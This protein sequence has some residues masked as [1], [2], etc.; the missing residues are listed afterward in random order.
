MPSY[1]R[2]D[3]PD[4]DGILI[5]SV[6]ARLAPERHFGVPADCEGL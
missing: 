4:M 2:S 6:A 5:V 3:P 1:G